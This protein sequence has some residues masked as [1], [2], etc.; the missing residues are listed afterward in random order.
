[1]TA[2]V[3]EPAEWRARAAAHEARVDGWVRPH[4]ER[5]RLG[6]KHPVE[7]F[8]FTYY[9]YRPAQ[10]RRWHPGAGVVLAGADP[11]EFRAG[12]RTV[13]TGLTVDVDVVLDRRGES[14][15]WIRD[16]LAATASR[17]AHLGCF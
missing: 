4:L 10:L 14:A 12:Y 16:L 9:P 2:T 17:T 13:E 7:D 3:L 11:D 1:M 5:R 6:K 8:L 15:R